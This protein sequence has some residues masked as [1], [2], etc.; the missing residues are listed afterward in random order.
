[1]EYIWQSKDFP[2]FV[3]NKQ[4]IVPLIQQFAHDLGEI[5]GIVMGFS[6][7]N[8][9]DL[10]AEVMLSEALKTSEIEGEYFS[11]EDVMS[12][13]KANLGIKDY[14]QNNRNKKANAIAHLM[15]EV[16]TAITSQFPKKYFWIGIIS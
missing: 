10:F 8:K 13:L 15:I 2:K 11:R 12:S 7:E 1:M 9:Q 14:H 16:Q 5:N 4:E 6:E 3:F